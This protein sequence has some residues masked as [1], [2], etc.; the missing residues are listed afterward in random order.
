MKIQIFDHMDIGSFLRAI[1]VMRKAEDKKFSYASWAQDLG[2]GN[3]TILRLILL[4]KRQITSKSAARFKNNMTFD[5]IESDYFDV[6]IEYSQ[7]KNRHNR[8]AL[9]Q[10]LIEIHRR[11]FKQTTVPIDIGILSDAYGP[12]ILTLLSSSEKALSLTQ[13]S[14]CLH[15]R[16]EV[17][18]QKIMDSL[19]RSKLISEEN[20]LFR[21]DRNN[22]KIGD[23][24][25]ASN[26]KKYYEYWIQK[27]SE[28]IEMPPHLRRFRSLHIALSQDEFDE[29]VKKFNDFALNLLSR[30][31]TNT[32][33]QRRLYLMNN[34]LF[35]A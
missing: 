3:K 17:E 33:E 4:G 31:E 13:I 18:L 32:I 30:F 23:H 6:L 2:F 5:E 21:A 22:F 25:G 7:A 35:P 28:A 1:Y 24:F 20:R 19:I 9:G 11:S 8:S 16:P 15:L 26:L 12:V 34:V 29:V 14:E 27:S 10:K